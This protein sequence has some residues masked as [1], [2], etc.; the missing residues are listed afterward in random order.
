MLFQKWFKALL[1]RG[2]SPQ[3]L[4]Q[5]TPWQLATHILLLRVTLHEVEFQ[6]YF[7]HHSQQ[8]AA[9]VAQCNTPSAHYAFCLE[10]MRLSL[11]IRLTADQGVQVAGFP[12]L[13]RHKSFEVAHF[14]TA[15]ETFFNVASYVDEKITQK[16]AG[17]LRSVEVMMNIFMKSKALPLSSGTPSKKRKIGEARQ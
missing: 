6:F 5:G 17:G 3:E 4:Q 12:R 10:R 2:I 13:S 9:A 7:S 8:F 14:A 15:T 16:I 11:W 1:N